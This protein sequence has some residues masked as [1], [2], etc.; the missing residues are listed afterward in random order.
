[1]W[2]SRPFVRKKC[3]RIALCDR[4]RDPDRM[5]RDGAVQGCGQIAARA[6][7]EMSSLRCSGI[8]FDE[9]RTSGTRFQ[10]EV[11][12]AHARELHPTSNFCDGGRH[13]SVFN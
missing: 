8:H 1:M 6:E 2:I 11:E 7:G 5:S 12:S 10:H 9:V 13:F 4:S 3:D